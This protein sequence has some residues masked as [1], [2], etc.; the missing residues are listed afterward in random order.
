LIQARKHSNF[1][2]NQGLSLPPLDADSYRG[3]CS[4]VLQQCA[5]AALYLIIVS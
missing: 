3:L 2:A 1:F 4:K 5:V